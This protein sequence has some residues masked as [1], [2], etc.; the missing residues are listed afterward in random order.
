MATLPANP[1]LAPE[2]APPALLR[3]AMLPKSPGLK[4]IGLE[5]METPAILALLGAGLSWAQLAGFLRDSG[6]SPAEIAAFLDLPERTFARRRSSGRF[7]KAETEKLI[8]LMEIYDS[9]LDLFGGDAA[10]T[11]FWLTSSV[12]GLN[13]A[14]PIDY[15][16]SDFGAREVRNLLGRIEHGVFS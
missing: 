10:A 4:R 13:N 6:V 12:R 9:A 11:H 3:E 2:Q 1:S 5:T 15:A 16:Q 14:R 8:R 7:G